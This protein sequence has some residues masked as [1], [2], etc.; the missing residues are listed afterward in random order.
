LPSEQGLAHRILVRIGSIS[1]FVAAALTVLWATLEAVAI[2]G[3]VAS[4]PIVLESTWFGHL[5]LA[6][7]AL[8]G[9]ALAFRRK[10]IA[11]VLAGLAVASMAGHEHA[12]AMVKGPSWLLASEILHL[13]AA[14]AWLGAL[15]PLAFLVAALP[16]SEAGLMSRRFA[17]LG[18]VC[19]VT[20]A[21]TALVQG[22]T[23]I[24]SIAGL[25]GTAYGLVAILKMALF[26]CL[27]AF[28]RRNRFRLTPALSGCEPGAAKSALIRSIAAETGAGLLLIFVAAL[29]TNLAPA[30]HAQPMWP[31]AWRV[32]L[33][34]VSGE[35]EFL[36]EA[37]AAGGAILLAFALAAAALCWRWRTRWLVVFL[38]ACAV[39]LAAPHLGVLLAEAYPTQYWSSP[40][41]F[42][43]SSIVEGAALYPKHCATCHG[44]EG[45]GDGPA[46]RSLA[47]PPADLT[48]THFWA[49]P[50]GELFWWLSHGIA[51]PDGT[52][53][54]PG[55]A[56]A[57]TQD[58]RWAL[59]DW[60]RAHNAGLAHTNS[61][62]WPVPV[63]APRFDLNCSDPNRTNVA[64]LRGQ[65]V[66][67]VFRSAPAIP[68][69]VTVL[70]N[71]TARPASDLC[72]GRDATV[73]EAY[74][75]VTGLSPNDLRNA[76]ILVD[77]AG[78]LRSVQ[79]NPDP[80]SLA[81]DITDIQAHPISPAGASHAGMKM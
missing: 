67:M 73:S 26:A 37:I 20:L 24:G 57:L 4:L 58:Q 66:R 33:D 44:A 13:L 75:I 43:V 68:G 11:A 55:F 38:A 29:L 49:H 34:A 54:M 5:S 51:G 53:V 47:E 59:I 10:A 7:L 65:V 30:M 17:P 78:W 76:T 12:I 74:A 2:G 14:G 36:Q 21:G 70:I 61:G 60:V 63:Q 62:A 69:A 41:S 42:S 32:S 40:T 22:S 48:A 56:S 45:R 71:Q 23:L 77:P 81:R 52:T 18:T 79:M 1:L 28:A 25:V 3:S 64:D 19:V 9:V 46:A 8:S 27:L 72:V 39:W 50:D 6:L 16:I 15:A 80:S 35:P 31:F